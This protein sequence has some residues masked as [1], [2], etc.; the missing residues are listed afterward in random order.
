MKVIG[1]SSGGTGHS[2]NTDRMVEAVLEKS[3]H[4]TE[5]VKLT[6]LNYSACKGCVQLCAGPQVCLLQDEATPYYQ[7]IKDADAVVMGSPVY[8][9][10]INLTALSFMERFFGYRHVTMALQDKPF[11]VVVCGFRMIDAAVEQVR[12]K[13]K[14]TGAAL[15]DLVTFLSGSPP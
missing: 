8:A 2:G 4:Q 11:L 9:G 3:G 12:N 14:F 15:L 5:F 7:K 1:F 13:V 10:S 6:D